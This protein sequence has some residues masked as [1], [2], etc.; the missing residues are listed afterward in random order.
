MRPSKGQNDI[1]FRG[2]H[3]NGSKKGDHC[4]DRG[5]GGGDFHDKGPL[6]KIISGCVCMLP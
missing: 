6:F 3:D 4:G 5:C 1:G 2:G